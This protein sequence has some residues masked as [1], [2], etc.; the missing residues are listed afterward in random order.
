M[1]PIPN[2]HAAYQR[3]TGLA[4]HLDMAR[5]RE[6]FDWLKRGFTE[7]DLAAVIAFHRRTVE[8]PRILGRMLR[9]GFL[10]GQPDRFEEDLAEARAQGARRKAQGSRQVVRTGQTER[11]VPDAGTADTSR[12]ARE[13]VAGLEPGSRWTVSP[14]N[15]AA[16]EAM[17]RG[18]EP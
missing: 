5:E 8:D 1:T 3:L 11:R 18:L 15:L 17:K 7:D 6:W 14:E 9:F 16:W 2:L 4:I 10:I 13:V 12:R